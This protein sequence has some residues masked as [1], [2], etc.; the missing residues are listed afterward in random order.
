MKKRAE[1]AAKKVVPIGNEGDD[2]AEAEWS[3]SSST[4]K[5]S[6]GK[7][8]RESE[9]KVEGEAPDERP[10]KNPK[11][12]AAKSSPSKEVAKKKRTPSPKRKGNMQ[13]EA[14]DVPEVVYEGMT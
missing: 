7:G 10:T 1:E 6:G 5:D 11:K 13:K 4:K 3:P 2:E 12:K 14:S 9:K 8:S